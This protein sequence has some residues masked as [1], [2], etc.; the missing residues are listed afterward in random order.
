MIQNSSKKDSAS[1][2]TSPIKE[3]VRLLRY[4][5]ATSGENMWLIKL[6]A[7]LS[8]LASTEGNGSLLILFYQFPFVED[9]IYIY[10]SSA[11]NA[12]KSTN[13]SYILSV[14]LA[15]FPYH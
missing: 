7:L 10:H 5:L 4:Y 3:N 1:F 8:A 14:I 6:V 2:R 15:L 13:N 11:S 12:Y 9:F